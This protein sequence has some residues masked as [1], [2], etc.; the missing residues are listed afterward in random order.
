MKWRWAYGLRAIV[1]IALLGGGALAHGQT[2]PVAG[3]VAAPARTAI[4][5]GVIVAVRVVTEDGRVLSD[6]PR[7]VP[8][9]I[10]KVLNRSDVAA[11][12]KALYR[13]GDY[14][15]LSAVTTAVP[16]GIRLD[17][18]AK[19][20][21]FF[22]QVTI[23]GLI[24]PPSDAS[25][26]AAMQINLGDIYRRSTVDEGLQRLRDALRDDGLY[27]AEATAE[28]VPYPARH[29]MDIVVHIEPGPRAHIGEIQLTN[30]T[31]YGDTELLARTKLKVGSS[32]TS[33]RLQHGTERVRKY[34]IK[35]EH[36]SARA[37]IRRGEYD[38]AKNTVPLSLDVTEG[39]RIKVQVTGAKISKGDLK[40][41]V[42]IY[43]EGAVDVDLL[44]EGKRNLRERQERDGYFDAQVDYQTEMHEASQN[45]GRGVS[46]NTN[47][48]ASGTTGTEEIITY[49]IERGERHKLV[50]IEIA[51][52]HYFPTELLKSRLQISAR[53]FGTRDHFSQRLLDSDAQSMRNV[54]ISNGFLDATVKA[55]VED[56]YQGKKGEQL[57]RFNIVEG[58][59][60]SVAS[61]SLEGLHAFKENALLGV[62]GSLPGQPYSE[63]NVA[64]DRDNILA[65]YFN[66]GFPQ[67]TFTS[68]AERV[69]ASAKTETPNAG[70]PGNA[71]EAKKFA[72]PAKSEVPQAEPVRL[73]YRIQEGPQTRVR[74]VLLSGYRHTRENVIQREV[75]VKA[76]APLREGDV[77][78]SQRR[79]YN[80][81]IFNRVTIGPQNPNGTDPDKDIVVLVEEAKRYT[82]AYGGGFEVQRLA[83]TS[84]PTAGEVQ[85]APR[86]IF[87]IT[88][89]N[90]TGRADSL[91]LK[92]RGS[93]IEDRVLLGYTHPNLYSNPKLNLQI[94]AYTEKSQD[95][96]T[97]TESRYQGSIQIS[98]AVTSHTTLVYRYAFRKVVISNLNATV[99]PE[100]V[101]LFEQPTLVSEFGFTWFRDTRDNPAEATKGTF[102]SAD[103]SVAS[104]AIGSS[105]SFTR[106]F[107]QNSTYYPIK[108]HFSFAR[109][110]RIGILEPFANT[111]TLTFP[112]QEGTPLPELI[113]LP[114]RFFA[115]GGTSLRGFALNQAGPRDSSTGFPVGGQALL[116]LNQE[117]RFP[118]H[119]PFIG[120]KLGG[121]IF[122]DGGNVY[123]QLSHVTFRYRPPTPVFD[124]P[125]HCEFNCTN[126]LNYFSHTVGF[127]VRY[128]TPVGPIRVDLGY[129]IN[130]PL[131]VIPVPVPGGGVNPNTC[132]TVCEGTRLAK[133]QV[134]FNL[135]PSF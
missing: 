39:P 86:G 68:T 102:N 80:L 117:F 133:F 70:A 99:S 123:S 108:G 100:E 56:N 6:C 122:Y 66:E 115:G 57:V 103:F 14:A 128:A 16:G 77:V 59:Q 42:P 90:L 36:L 20:N 58:P 48:R 63:T 78:E 134:F 17:F 74:R 46:S 9:E 25:A 111:V 121:A 28:L 19:E 91:S 7:G 62:V 118:M 18:V 43:Q 13:T 93:T 26:A 106:F 3:D 30:G 5:E 96:N 11:G 107:Y 132:P 92:I 75:R 85:A 105:A 98:E 55:V 32:L 44:E 45:T 69:S 113:P 27:Q 2:V 1:A 82:I 130:R 38:A 120:S 97:F 12:L 73:V 4:P 89:N 51:G 33:E 22:N 125:T 72:D 41:L 35:K 52:N 101:P 29:Q 79:L 64:T 31:E 95:I 21:L 15:Y 49:H 10:G 135:G 81:G 126:E 110:I 60:T 47:N 76:N 40:R 114:E 24:A 127:G 54:Y 116:A 34:L 8:V 83:S 131:F 88:R 104:T 65:L 53:S 84:S 61:L 124:T 129:Q 119:L 109:S 37:V 94:T 23:E 87:E 71:A 67:A 50:K 112:P